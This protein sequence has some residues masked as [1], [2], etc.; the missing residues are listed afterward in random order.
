[1]NDGQYLRMAAIVAESSKC[2]S[3]KVGAV[4]VREGRIIS[5]GYN[6]TPPGTPN[7]CE[8]HRERGP[9]H[10]EWSNRWEIHAEMNCILFAGRNGI[11]V[12]NT[13]MYTTIEP[14][15]QCLKNMAAAG[16][17]FI[18]YSEPY[19]RE[20][21]DIGEK[22]SFASL[23]GLTLRHYGSASTGPSTAQA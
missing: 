20:T 11:S 12:E 13:T 4:L 18:V 5:I 21:I 9:E 23:C 10:S 8:V 7:C 1:M 16:V 22:E 19:Y 3:L 17:K 6:G 14:C 15:T 2:V